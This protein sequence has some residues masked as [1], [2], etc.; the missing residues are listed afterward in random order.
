MR[1]TKP[2]DLG[3]C[4]ICEGTRGVRNVIM[5]HQKAPLAGRGWGCVVCGL[6]AGGAVA[7]L[8]DECLEK[9]QA[10]RAALKF[11]CRGYPGQDGRV[12]FASLTGQHEHDHRIHNAEKK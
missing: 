5:L 12:P 7:V 10:K 6:P 8:C 2:S 1:T 3:P 4:C 9:F 11:A